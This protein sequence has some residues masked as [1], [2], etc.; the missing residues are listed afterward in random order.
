MTNAEPDPGSIS[1]FG[2]RHSLLTR[3]Q[4]L[5]RRRKL[6]LV[7]ADPGSANRS[8]LIDEERRRPRDVPRVDADAVPHAVGA[9]HVAPLVDQDVERQTGVFDVAAHGLAFLREDADDLDAPG[10]VVGDVVGKLTKLVAAVRSPHAAME[11]QQQSSAGEE[12]GQRSRAP[13]LIGQHE[14]GRARQR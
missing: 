2:I 11:C 5:L 14:S 12:V 10:G 3:G 8:I 13:F 4:Y 1:S 7:R 9:Q 6:R